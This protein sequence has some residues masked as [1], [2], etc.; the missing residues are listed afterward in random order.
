MAQHQDLRVLRGVRP[1]QQSGP[2]DQPKEDQIDQTQRHNVDHAEHHPPASHQVNHCDWITGTHTVVAG[3]TSWL[4]VGD[5]SS[6]DNSCART[7]YNSRATT[8][9]RSSSAANQQARLLTRVL[10]QHR[11]VDLLQRRLPRIQEPRCQAL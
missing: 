3:V 1:R 9:H 10:D 2:A 8:T 11:H 4:P 7:R 6:Q 5:A